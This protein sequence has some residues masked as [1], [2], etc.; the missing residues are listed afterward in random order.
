MVEAEKIRFKGK[1]LADQLTAIDGYFKRLFVGEGNFATLNT[2]VLKSNSITADKL[3][4]D[5]AMARLLFQAISSRT[6]LLLKL[7]L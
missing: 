2:E 1:T 7:R 3:V 5:M 4:M 6:R